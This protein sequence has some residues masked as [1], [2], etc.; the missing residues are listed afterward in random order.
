M[1]HLGWF[2]SLLHTYCFKPRLFNNFLISLF[3]HANL[4][5]LVSLA[6]SVKT[7]V[8]TEIKEFGL[9][10]YL[11]KNSNLTSQNPQMLRV[12]HC[13]NLS[14]FGSTMHFNTLPIGQIFSKNHNFELTLLSGKSCSHKSHPTCT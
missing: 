1:K 2:T 6:A 12:I 11:E 8:L 13:F 4:L 14:M 5:F 9:S 3:N 7:S 10:L